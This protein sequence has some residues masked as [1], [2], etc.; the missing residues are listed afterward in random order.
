M[1]ILSK[2]KKIEEKKRKILVL[3]LEHFHKLLE[4]LSVEETEELS[5]DVLTTGLFVVH[6]SSGGG[7]HNVSELTGGEEVPQPRLELLDGH[8][9]T[10]A[11]D[12]TLVDASQELDHNLAGTVVVNDLEL[13]NVSW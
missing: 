5:S 2:K 6:N 10:G 7:D 9:V 8:I 3:L 13:T 4:R 12:T 11:D 1:K